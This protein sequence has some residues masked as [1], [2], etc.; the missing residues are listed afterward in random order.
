MAGREACKFLEDNI[1]ISVSELGN[2]ALINCAKTSMNSK[3]IGPE[4]NFF[5]EMAVNGIYKKLFLYNISHKII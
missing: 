5:A 3:L 2:D 4:S 1:A